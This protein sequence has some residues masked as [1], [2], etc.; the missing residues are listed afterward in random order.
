MKCRYLLLLVF[1]VLSA[2]MVI[3]PADAAETNLFEGPIL[4]LMDN[5]PESIT[6][7]D[8]DGDG[9]IDLAVAN[10]HSCNIAVMLGNGDGYFGTAVY[11]STG[12]STDPRSITSADFDGDG[13][14]DLLTA[15][16]STGDVAILL[17]NGDGTFI[18]PSYYLSGYH[19][20]FVISSDFDSDSNMDVAVSNGGENAVAIL[21]GNG[22]GSFDAPVSYSADSIPRSITA[23]DFDSDGKL[24]LATGNYGSANLSVLMGNGDGT[25]DAAVNYNADDQPRSITSCDLNGDGE[26]DLAVANGGADNISVLSGNGDGT[27]AAAVNYPAD[28]YPISVICG[29]FNIDG[30]TD[31][32]AANAYTHTVSILLGSGDG[33]F[34][35]AVNFGS[36]L[37]PHDL[38][39]S[40]FNGDGDP[41]LAVANFDADNLSIFI[42]IYGK[43]IPDIVS[44]EDIP[45][46]QG[47]Y[48][49]LN[50]EPSGDDLADEEIITHYSIWRA[51]DKMTV[52]SSRFE[53][54][55][56]ADPADIGI[57]F[58]G[59]AY[60][61]EYTAG[62]N[63]FWEWVANQVDF[64]FPGYSYS[65]PTRYDSTG[66]DQGMHYFQIVAHTYD[67]F[68]Y[69]KSRPDSGYSVD[70][71]APCIPYCFTGEYRPEPERLTLFWHPN[72]NDADLYGYRIYRGEGKDFIP[73]EENL[74]AATTDTIVSA[75]PYYPV[76]P[77][78]FKLAAVDIHGNESRMAVLAPTEVPIATLVTSSSATWVADGVRVSW[79]IGE[80]ELNPDYDILRKEEDR[81]FE[82]IDCNVIEDENGFSFVDESAEPGRRYTYQVD[83]IDGG[84]RL[85]SFQVT[86]KTPAAKFALKQNSPNPFN[87]STSIEF[88]LS[89]DGH[90][91][92]SVFDASGR[93]VRNIAQGFMKAGI[94][95]ETWNGTDSM[96]REVSSGI[97]FIRLRSKE[98]I[99]SRKA[100]LMR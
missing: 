24:D 4:Y 51:V 36:D 11:Y 29:D 75:L 30:I 70:N 3:N 96:G 46:D 80:G 39:S 54:M 59:A 35:M 53:G 42:N 67:Q 41:D 95:S 62:G 74:I 27:F 14:I 66:S 78:Y 58:D 91:E 55:P 63:Y 45:N 100:V 23:G 6:S 85:A 40:D 60:R 1:S 73:R 65:V 37:K 5:G 26:L 90:A 12:N 2:A 57:D 94:H 64:N 17:G 38:I 83:L 43:F 44:V 31:L 20:N 10:E 18:S 49:S 47:G 79:E 76:Q 89:E 72:N 69:W 9:N 8:F 92:L 68:V 16:N 86:V 52:S 15:N 97:Y 33:S 25:F 98:R 81:D 28:D 84:T 88:S 82:R 87:P 93:L 56:P 32:A 48:V 22:D 77:W 61:I 13:N 71:L 34:E 7:N 99:I 21:L 19:P 50:W